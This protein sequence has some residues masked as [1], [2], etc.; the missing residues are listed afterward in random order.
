MVTLPTENYGQ[1]CLTDEVA[2]DDA[3]ASAAHA[4]VA[5]TGWMKS[6]FLNV[7]FPFPKESDKL[8]YLLVS[9]YSILRYLNEIALL[10]IRFIGSMVRAVTS[11]SNT[12]SFLNEV[13]SDHILATLSYRTCISKHIR[14]SVLQGMQKELIYQSINIVANFYLYVVIN[15]AYCE[16]ATLIDLQ[17]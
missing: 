2:I 9:V 1:Y 17:A 4:D 6:S 5:K 12:I 14:I 10:P 11:S 7:M 13:L 8:L 16:L 3:M 15:Y